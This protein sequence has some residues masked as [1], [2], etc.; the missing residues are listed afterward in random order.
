MPVKLINVDPIVDKCDMV[1]KWRE[2]QDN[3]APITRYHVYRRIAKRGGTPQSWTK[4]HSASGRV[5][6]YHVFHLERG[7]EYDFKVTAENKI[8]EGRDEESH[9]KRVKVREG[10]S[11]NNSFLVN[12]YMYIFYVSTQLQKN[13]KNFGISSFPNLERVLIRRDMGSE[14]NQSDRVSR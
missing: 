8:G 4:I 7:T 3:G 9:S 11:G 1:L 2:P 6:E 13:G 14:S 12:V 10:E 5:F